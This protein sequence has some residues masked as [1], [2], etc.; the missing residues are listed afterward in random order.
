MAR[1][2]RLRLIRAV[3]PNR[4][5]SGPTVSGRGRYRPCRRF[6]RSVTDA[7]ELLFGERRLRATSSGWTDR[8]SLVGP[9]ET[10]R[11]YEAG[12]EPECPISPTPHWPARSAA[13]EPFRSR[14][15]PF[16]IPGFFSSV[17][18]QRKAGDPG[19]AGNSEQ[20][21]PGLPAFFSGNDVE[22]F[23]VR[24]RALIVSAERP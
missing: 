23:F 19:Q 15:L 6:R 16:V 9:Q 17:I 18:P 5:R 21:G 7:G 1:P 3:F 2:A 14:S 24:L 20:V 13:P 4:P 8:R 11:K 12:L 10:G 22:R